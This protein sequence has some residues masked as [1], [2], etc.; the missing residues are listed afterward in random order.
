MVE[1]WELIKEKEKVEPGKTVSNTLP[2]SPS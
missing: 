1:N 2:K